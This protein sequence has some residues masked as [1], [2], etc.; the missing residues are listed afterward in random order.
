MRENW[1]K[2]SKKVYNLLVLFFEQMLFGVCMRASC[3]K[4]TLWAVLACAV[5]ALQS[6]KT[7]DTKKLLQKCLLLGVGKECITYK[8]GEALIENMKRGGH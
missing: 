2:A 7:K 3:D 1:R 4:I 8:L 5:F 6:K